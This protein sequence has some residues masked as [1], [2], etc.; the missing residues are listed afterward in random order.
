VWPGTSSFLQLWPQVRLCFP[1]C[2]TPLL[3]LLTGVLISGRHSRA[4]F[5][6]EYPDLFGIRCNNSVSKQNLLLFYLFLGVLFNAFSLPFSSL[7]FLFFL[8]LS[9]NIFFYFFS[10]NTFIL[11][12]YVPRSCRSAREKSCRN[13]SKSPS[14]YQRITSLKLLR[15]FLM[16]LTSYMFP[17]KFY[18]QSKCLFE[19]I[20]LTT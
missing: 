12:F 7:I 5:R 2:G 6:Y 8:Y 17:A 18:S 4:L 15:V 13:Y 1:C 9:N 10:F 14:I 20:F 3:D 11:R 16:I 19:P